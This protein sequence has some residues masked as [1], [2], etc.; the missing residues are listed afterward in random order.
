MGFEQL[1]ELRDQLKAEKEQ[2]KTDRATP[3]KRKSSPQSKPR[4]RDPAMEAIWPLQR[5]FPLAFPVNPA[6]K[7]PLKEGILKDAEQHLELLGISL[8]QLKLGIST[9]CRG[10]RYWASMV[11]NAPRL[12]LS[13]QPAG[14]VTA[15]QAIH[16]KQQAS[17]QRSQVR[18]NR[19]KA[20]ALAV[21]PDAN[22]AVDTAPTE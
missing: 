5:H 6:P 8:E 4:E 22:T 13:G 19:G 9:W 18:R 1:A 12:D 17:R 3:H 16:A 10:A 15:A 7:V 11:E 14:V 20:Q 21:E 2:A